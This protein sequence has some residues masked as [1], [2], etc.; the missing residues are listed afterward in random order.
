MNGTIGPIAATLAFLSIVLAV[1]VLVFWV[2]AGIS[3]NV[4]APINTRDEGLRAITANCVHT[5]SS[6]P[7]QLRELLRAVLASRGVDLPEER[8]PRAFLGLIARADEIEP[9]TLTEAA[10]LHELVASAAAIVSQQDLS[11]SYYE[12]AEEFLGT[13]LPRVRVTPGIEVALKSAPPSARRNSKGWRAHVTGAEQPANA[14]ELWIARLAWGSVLLIP[15]IKG[16]MVFTRPVGARQPPPG[17]AISLGFVCVIFLAIN[18]FLR[19]HRKRGSEWVIRPTPEGFRAEPRRFAERGIEVRADECWTFVG[20]VGPR[21]RFTSPTLVWTFVV[22]DQPGS[23][24]CQNF[25][26]VGTPW[27][28]WIEEFL[29]AFDR[30]RERSDANGSEHEDPQPT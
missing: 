5:E 17:W 23:L 13:R 29:G 30:A 1:L 4:L 27:Q 10:I 12:R 3:A 28:S 25:S 6:N 9:F 26:A 14:I 2:I 22:R 11:W 21:G 24:S 15:I 20:P 16:V 7:R 19:W 8:D 18:W